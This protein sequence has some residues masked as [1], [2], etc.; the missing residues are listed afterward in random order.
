[1]DYISGAISYLEVALPLPLSQEAY[2]KDSENPIM[3]DSIRNSKALMVVQPSNETGIAKNPSGRQKSQKDEATLTFLEKRHPKNVLPG[4][5][6]S[7]LDI[8]A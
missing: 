2:Q 7:L 1:M 8:Y 3:I 5:K 6:G 4:E